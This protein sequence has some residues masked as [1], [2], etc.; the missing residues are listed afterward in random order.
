MGIHRRD[1]L[2]PIYVFQRK[3]V[4]DHRRA[5][6]GGLGGHGGMAVFARRRRAFF[7]TAMQMRLPRLSRR[8]CAT[9]SGRSAQRD[10]PLQQKESKKNQK[11]TIPPV[12]V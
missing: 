9:S 7:V 1:K 5:A 2:V 10:L 3:R 8:F 6:V 4:R 12:T 11:T